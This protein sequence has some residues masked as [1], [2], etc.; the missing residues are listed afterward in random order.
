MFGK[1]EKSSVT[2]EEA[3]RG[4]QHCAALILDDNL[5]E[6]AGYEQKLKSLIR[7][8]LGNIPGS[9]KDVQVI[10]GSAEV[11]EGVGNSS[12]LISTEAGVWYLL[13]SI[14]EVRGTDEVRRCK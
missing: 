9:Y 8:V 4:L 12:D 3:I 10:E 1:L 7:V 13:V 2:P 14:L 11:H 5:P 6:E